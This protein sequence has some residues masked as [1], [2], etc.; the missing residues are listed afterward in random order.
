MAYKK[1]KYLSTKEEE[2]K[3]DELI[4]LKDQNSLRDTRRQWNS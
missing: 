4:S 2:I 3:K 1:S